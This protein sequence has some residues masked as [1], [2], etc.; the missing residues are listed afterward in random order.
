M[1]YT[2]TITCRVAIQICIGYFPDGRERHR[3]FSMKGI[4]PDARDEAIA[5]VVRALA[6][7]LAYPITKVRKIIKRVIVFDDWAAPAAPAVQMA[8][9][10]AAAPVETTLVETMPA[11]VTPTASPGVFV[12]P[13]SIQEIEKTVW[14]DKIALA[15]LIVS[16]ALRAQRGQ[17]GFGPVR[18]GPVRAPP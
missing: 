11:A 4:R 12:F 6:P 16:L 18:L 13:V 14:L 9:A 17:A 15:A 7:V 5:A 8:A 3:T 2:E 10:Q 1:T